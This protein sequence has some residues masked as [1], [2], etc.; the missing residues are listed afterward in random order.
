[1]SFLNAYFEDRENGGLF[2]ALSEDFS[3]VL[4]PDKHAGDQFTAART[5]V[6]G[7]M[8]THD[9]ET[10]RD[11]EAAVGDV[12]KKFEDTRHGGYFL[13]ADR[14]WNIS[15]KDKSLNE[16]G[17][18]FGVL[19][20]LYEVSKN[21]AYLL[22]GLEFI[23]TAVDRAWD[24]KHGGFFSLYHEDWKPAADT[25]DLATQATM[26]QHING[27]WKDGMDSPFGARS[28]AHKEKAE[29]FG[30]LLIEKCA[31]RV[32]G[33]FY[34][35][36]TPDWKPALRDKD[37]AGLASFAL[38]LYF[39]YHNLGPSIW[40]PRKGSH[41]YTGRPYPAVYAYRGPAPGIDPVSDKA[42]RFGKTVLEIGDLLLQHAWDSGHGGFYTTLT[43]SLAPKDTAKLFAT[44]I[45]CLMALNVAYRLTGFKRFQQRLAETV[46]I[47]EDRCFD[48][49]NGGVYVSFE[50]DWKPARREKVCGPNLM[51]M[52]ILSMM[53]P[54]VNDVAVTRQT[55]CL[56]VD[57][58]QQ[59]IDRN[60]AGQCTVTVQNQGFEQQRVRIGGLTT[61]SR[62]M[63]PGD[64]VF[65][66]APHE[67]RSYS[68]TIRPPQDMP[69]GRYPFE[70]TCMPEGAV[71]EY[72]AAGGM[73]TI[74]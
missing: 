22:R 58:Q 26:L 33:G 38:T 65:D 60:S 63:Q 15:N 34:T 62:W 41:A 70:I 19:M 27:S 47:M 3:K 72:V 42:C 46:K 5:S 64:V 32:N 20:H 52:G 4:V 50:P 8:I 53:T 24:K 69:A 49:D 23:D 31:D 12:M 6:I 13:A 17:E 74:R 28:A 39:H 25:K 66:L 29:Q 56:W 44:Q 43:E 71:A 45:S 59:T 10:I 2:H 11:A 1:M 37:V 51:S 35:L 57:P 68:L 36:L 55:L 18:I 40:G 16:T 48:P 14:Q 9:P 30:D 21:D 67:V 7:A 61:P 54:V 73:I